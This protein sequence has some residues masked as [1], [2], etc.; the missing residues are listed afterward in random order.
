MMRVLLGLMV[1][2]GCGIVE[3]KDDTILFELEYA[4]I[5]YEIQL[6]QLHRLESEGYTCA[7]EG[8]IRDF[9]GREVGMKYRCTKCS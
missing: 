5:F 2:A 8:A 1:L 6:G 3:C 7:S 4:S 9:L